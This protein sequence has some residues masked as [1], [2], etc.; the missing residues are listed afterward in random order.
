MMCLSLIVGV[1]LGFCICRWMPCS[2]P[3]KGKL[4]LLDH[5]FLAK[6]AV[7]KAC[8]SSEAKR[9]KEKDRIQSQYV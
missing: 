9:K 8:L 6:F 2:R 7:N 3:W 1:R 4:W 5:S